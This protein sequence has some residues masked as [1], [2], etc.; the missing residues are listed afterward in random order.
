MKVLASYS[1]KGGVGKTTTA[2]NL[3]WLAADAGKRVLLW[4]LDPQ[5]GSTF[6]FRVAPKV[7]GGGRA[8]IGGKRELLDAV[9]ASDFPGLDLLPADFSYRH[10]DRYLD[11]QK[12]PTQ[13]LANLLEDMADEYDLVIMDCAPSVTLISENVVRAAD[14]ILAPV[15]PSPLSMRTLDQLAGFA[16]DTKGRTPPILAFFSMVDSRR[17]LHRDLAETVPPKGVELAKTSIPSASAIEL[18]GVRRAPV[19]Q[20]APTSI[21]GRAYRALWAEV[22]DRLK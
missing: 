11:E 18:M 15:L 13:R 9:K 10:L 20:F 17:K 6:L 5:G 4:D 3:G 16:D 21:P 7:K 19:A 12:R 2:A 1:I 8:L 14:L 22:T